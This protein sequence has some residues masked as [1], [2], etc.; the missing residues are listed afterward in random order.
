LLKI[1]GPPDSPTRAENDVFT[2]AEK[3]EVARMPYFY[4]DCG[5]DDGLLP[6]NRQF[7]AV[8]QNRKIAYEYRELPGAHT[9]IY[10]DQQLP[11]ML[12]VLAQH[13]EIGPRF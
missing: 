12:R 1:Y 11:Q 5:T 6:G 2:L 9:W 7:V 3:A 8:L 4:V 13:M 10:W